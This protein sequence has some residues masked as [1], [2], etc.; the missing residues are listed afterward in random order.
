MMV[1]VALLGLMSWL[2][3]SIPVAAHADDLRNG[4]KALQEGRQEDALKAFEK[5][6]AQGYGAGRAGVGQVWLRRRQYEK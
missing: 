2:G 5:A 1:R 4:Q 3:A 6:A